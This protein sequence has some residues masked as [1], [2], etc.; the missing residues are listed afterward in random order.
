M[1]LFSRPS[2]CLGLL[3]FITGFI[4]HRVQCF[5]TH[6][7]SWFLSLFCWN[8][9]VGSFLRFRVLRL[10]RLGPILSSDIVWLYL[11]F[12]LENNLLFWFLIYF[13]SSAYACGVCVCV[14]MCCACAGIQPRAHRSEESF[15]EPVFSS[16]FMWAPDIKLVAGCMQLGSARTE[17]SGGPSSSLKGCFLLN[18]QSSCQYFVQEPCLIP[19]V[20]FKAHLFISVFL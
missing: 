10:N 15:E 20:P 7:F 19:V 12:L 13:I 16:T 11:T 17:P 4:L 5:L 18:C 6:L 3:A 1:G 2:C 8:I 9:S 14:Y